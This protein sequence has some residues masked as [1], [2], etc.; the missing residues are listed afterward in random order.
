MPGARRTV[1]SVLAVAVTVGALLRELPACECGPADLVAAPSPEGSRPSG[2]GMPPA[3][4]SARCPPTPPGSGTGFRVSSRYPSV[5]SRFRVRTG[6]GRSALS[7][8]LRTTEPT[9][10][11][12]VHCVRIRHRDLRAR[13]KCRHLGSHRQ[14][15][16]RASASSCPQA[17][18]PQARAR[19]A[20]P[21][22]A[23]KH[24]SRPPRFP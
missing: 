21:R 24:A 23:H 7:V 3:P 2:L 9:R 22:S 17:A 1:R 4:E 10:R 12:T 19:L 16:G 13:H 5:L 8:A 6:Q 18:T 20:R 14:C 15:V 11:G